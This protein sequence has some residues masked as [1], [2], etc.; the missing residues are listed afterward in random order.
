MVKEYSVKAKR[1]LGVLLFIW[2]LPFFSTAQDYLSPLMHLRKIKIRLTG[3]DPSFEEYRDFEESIRDCGDRE[4]SH[5]ENFCVRAALRE[6]VGRFFSSSN[7]YRKSVD[8]VFD[9][10]QSKYTALP[11]GPKPLGSDMLTNLAVSIFDQNLSWD[12]FFTSASFSLGEDIGEVAMFRDATIPERDY[13]SL[14]LPEDERGRGP[15][16]VHIENPHLAA[17]FVLTKEFFR[18]FFNNST[19]QGRSRAAAIIR[20][21]LCDIM[22]PEVV[23]NSI[24]EMVEDTIARGGRQQPRQGGSGDEHGRREDCMNCHIGRGLDPL[25]QTFWAT[26]LILSQH[27]FPGRFTYTS[28]DG[29]LF[30]VPVEG[31]GHWMRVLVTRPEYERCQVRH[32]WEHFVG[33]S[34]LLDENPQLMQEVLRVFNEKGRRVLDFFEYLLLSDEFARKESSR[35]KQNSLFAEVSPTFEGCFSCHKSSN[36]IPDFRRLPI[37]DGGETALYARRILERLALGPYSNLPATMPPPGTLSPTG[38]QL[39]SILRWIRGGMPDAS[40]KMHLSREEVENIFGTPPA[41]SIQDSSLQE[42]EILLGQGHRRILSSRD[43]SRFVS[44]KFPFSFPLCNFRGVREH[45]LM[46]GF[47]PGRG[48]RLVEKPESEFAK[49]YLQCLGSIHRYMGFHRYM[50]EVVK[51]IFPASLVRWGRD[52]PNFSTVSWESIPRELRRET[53]GYLVSRRVGPESVLE[54]LRYIGPHSLL[55]AAP[56]SGEELIDHLVELEASGPDR[57]LAEVVA[58]IVQ[59]LLSVETILIH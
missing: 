11:A 31:I 25:A 26:E 43:L 19:N 55:D 30:D 1:T 59:I 53:L 58:F 41:D 49:I 4:V 48:T 6:R 2:I 47:V 56:Q 28:A 14:H 10:V 33:D 38:R 54:E 12:H 37:G 36:R 50:D 44:G 16:R 39:G 34:E 22:S 23:L 57:N 15:L 18:R 27:P 8:F 42:E 7:F 40:G 51:E 35:Q 20:I 24:H 5:P 45:I 52:Y 13:F 17:G 32:F 29:E 9:L 3:T 46:G 21:G